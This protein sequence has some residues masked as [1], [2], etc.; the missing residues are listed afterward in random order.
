MAEKLGM[1]EVIVATDNLFAGTPG[2]F[3]EIPVE[4]A[5]GEGVLARG[6]VLG[7]ITK[8]SIVIAEAEDNT[9]DGEPGE[10]TIGQMAQPGQYVLKC[11]AAAEGAGTF[12]VYD[13]Q[14]RRMSDL[15]VA[16][17]YDNGHFAVTI[18]AGDT[19]F[20]VGDIFTVTV[21]AGTNAG[22]YRAYGADNTDGS[23]IARV[24]LGRDVDAS[25]ADVKAF[26]YA[27]GVFKRSALTGIDDA[28]VEA[29]ADRGIFVK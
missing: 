2:Q 29:L 17:A 19:D 27:G 22:K 25:A 21:A 24:I 26:A 15:T 9:G 12:Q 28:A 11:T 6:T 7:K 16:V 23:G 10:I 4:I 1:N 20:V 3:P 14:G 13:P 18:A 5:A 8:G